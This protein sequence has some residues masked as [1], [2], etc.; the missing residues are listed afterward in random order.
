MA[1]HG[2]FNYQSSSVSR[3]K[4]STGKIYLSRDKS[5]SDDLPVGLD[6]VPIN[7]PV[8]DA[9]TIEYE[10]TLNKEGFCLTDHAYPHIG[11]L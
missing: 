6:P 3:G 11:N 10:L 5:G 2:T 9:R 1:T 4:Y 7:V 8:H